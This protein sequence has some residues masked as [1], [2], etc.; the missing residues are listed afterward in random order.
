MW[1]PKDPDK[2][3][4]KFKYVEFAKWAFSEKQ[5][6]WSVFRDTKFAGEGNPRVPLLYTWAQVRKKLD[7]D[8]VGYYT[9]TFAFDKPD[10]AHAQSISSLYFDLDSSEKLEQSPQLALDDV[11][12]LYGHLRTIVPEDSIRLY[13]SGKKGFHL[14]CEALALGIGPAA[15]LPETFRFI[16]EDMKET[17][18]IETI[19]FACYDARRMWRIP[20][21]KHQGTGLY[22]IHLKPEE[23]DL[24]LD[25]IQALAKEP[26]DYKVPE[27]KFSLDA[28]EWFRS[29]IYKKVEKSVSNE[30]R[31]TRF[32]RNG[33]GMARDQGELVFDPTC[34][35]KCEALENLWQK[36]ETKHHLEH[37][38]RLM[39]C[40]LLTYSDEAISY[41]HSILSNCDDYNVDR[42]E[43]HIRD[44]IKRR[45]LGIGGRP[46][47]C[48]RARAAGIICGNCGDLEPRDR[49]EVVGDRMIP[50]G[51]KAKP[52][53]VRIMYT[54][55][56]S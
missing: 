12:K 53:P 3:T 33:S 27:P 16:A 55:K 22:K 1:I 18:S 28:N 23:L 15:D 7:P 8:G 41:L 38:E 40:S 42:S 43:S 13:F 49:Y 36:A 52:S 50:T 45:E 34:F 47:S 9:S 30:E 26:R 35:G 19:D 24:T 46:Y 14:E 51:E 29:Y 11:R 31:I 39:L 6:R 44:W 4:S 2:F 20:N 37:E 56:H 17:L 5:D 21:T 48:D 10:L 54:R 32:M 25:E